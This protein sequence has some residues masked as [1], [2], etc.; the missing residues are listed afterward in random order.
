MA[1]K[2]SKTREEIW[3]ERFTTFLQI[4]VT[5]IAYG[6]LFVLLVKKASRPVA[7]VC[8]P[9]LCYGA[10]QC[11]S[12]AISSRWFKFRFWSEDK[13]GHDVLDISFTCIALVNLLVI[14]YFI[15]DW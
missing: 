7:G 1:L 8:G 3:M 12:R 4:S 6:F 14:F 10:W 13:T 2:F 11:V 9:L 5:L 15:F